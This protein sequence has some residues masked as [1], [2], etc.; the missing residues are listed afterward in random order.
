MSSLRTIKSCWLS[1]MK[2]LNCNRSYILLEQITSNNVTLLIIRCFEICCS[3][4][5]IFCKSSFSYRQTERWILNISCEFSILIC[6]VKLSVI[7]EYKV[8]VMY[9]KFHCSYCAF[10]PILQTQS[11]CILSKTSN[12]FS[13]NSVVL[14]LADVV[15]M[16]YVFIINLNFKL[17]FFNIEIDTLFSFCLFRMYNIIFSCARGEN[18]VI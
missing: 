10:D 5:K 14:L 7:L 16:S 3:M 2:N 8:T 18:V 9:F 6:Q 11:N 17:I 12:W 4:L 15:E 13:Q 1:A